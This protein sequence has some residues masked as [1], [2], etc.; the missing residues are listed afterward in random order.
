M[1]K[2]LYT[3]IVLALILWIWCIRVLSTV[4]P[5][6][7]TNIL[8]FLISFFMALALTLSIP[9]YFFFYKKAPTF[10]NLKQLYRRSLKWSVF[11][12]F[13]FTA[14]VGLKAFGSLT[15]LNLL[16]FVILYYAMF[17]QLKR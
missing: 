5:D 7:L 11:L 8:Q 15:P 10:T 17:A 13:G 14:V 1:P 9:A 4:P 12:A 16:L 6:S 3:I 2:F